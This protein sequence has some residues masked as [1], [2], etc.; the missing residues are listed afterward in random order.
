MDNSIYEVEREDYR[1]FI[2]QLNKDMMDI[3]EYAYKNCYFTKIISKKTNKHLSSRISDSDLGE[4]HYFIFNYPNDD[5][6]IAPKSVLKIN[7][8]TREDVQNFFNALGE[9]QKRERS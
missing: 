9:L 6:R 2:E 5:E 3:E 4:E 1:N 8:D 7:L